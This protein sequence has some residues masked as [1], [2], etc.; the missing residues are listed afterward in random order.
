MDTVSQN[1]Y[2]ASYSYVANSPLISQI[3]YKQGSTT[4]MTV[5]RQYDKLNRMQSIS[6][7]PGTG[8]VGQD[9][10]SDGVRYWVESND[11]LSDPQGW[12][13]GPSRVEYVEGSR[14]TNADVTES[15]RVRMCDPLNQYPAGFL[16]VRA[17]IMP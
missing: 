16:R 4:R 8:T 13:G 12:W 15:V 5:T 3:T 9:Y 11:N 17:E 14:T 10:K 2:S 7:L 1:G 6:S